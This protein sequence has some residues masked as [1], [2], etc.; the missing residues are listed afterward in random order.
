[1]S[2]ERCQVPGVGCHVGRLAA[3]LEIADSRFKRLTGYR[4]LIPCH[5]AA[6]MQNC[7]YLEGLGF[8]P[9][10]DQVGIYRKEADICRGQI[11]SPV[12]RAGKAGEVD[13]FG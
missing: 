2:E 10:H 5:V 13:T 3:E 9:V 4:H 1:M 11:M 7:D 12:A 6:A 8:R